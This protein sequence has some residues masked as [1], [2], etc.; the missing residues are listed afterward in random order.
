MM[1]ARRKRTFT[2]EFKAR[3]VELVR[4]GGKSVADVCRE[5]NLTETAVRRWVAQADIDAGRR[6]GPRLRDG[7]PAVGRLAG[8]PMPP[9]AP[10]APHPS[11]PGFA[12]AMHLSCDGPT[13]GPPL[14]GRIAE[15]MPGLRALRARLFAFGGFWPEQLTG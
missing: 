7:A 12:A 14:P 6:D 1:T 3:T 15:Q 8:H 2:P 10:N 11:L 9:R 4:T 13:V 5:L